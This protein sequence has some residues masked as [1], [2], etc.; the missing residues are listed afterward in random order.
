MSVLLSSESVIF[1]DQPAWVTGVHHL[2]CH[3]RR[4]VGVIVLFDKVRSS[5]RAA[6]NRSVEGLATSIIAFPADQLRDWYALCSS[7]RLVTSDRHL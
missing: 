5:L 6:R 1:T 2:I 3:G 7:Y 4:R